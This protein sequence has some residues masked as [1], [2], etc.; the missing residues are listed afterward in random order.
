VIR[1][2]EA[3]IQEYTKKLEKNREEALGLQRGAEAK[4]AEAETLRGAIESLN[5]LRQQLVAA[6]AAP[7][8][9]PAAAAAAAPAA[10]PAAAAAA[11]PAAAAPAAAPA[12]PAATGSP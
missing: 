6:A 12:A 11:A 9:A 5:V 2:I 8:A 3:N 4:R 10:A 7:P 1:R